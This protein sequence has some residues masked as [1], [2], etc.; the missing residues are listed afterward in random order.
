MPSDKIPVPGGVIIACSR[1]QRRRQCS[2]PACHGWMVALCDFPLTGR[3]AGK[4]CD[5]PLCPA[6]RVKQPG[7]N[8]DYCP[9]HDALQKAG[10]LGGGEGS[11]LLLP[12]RPGPPQA[13]G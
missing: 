8:V 11:Q 3:K 12:A 1:G 4:T 9:A 10:G 6:H 13:G 7:E 5:K 2:V